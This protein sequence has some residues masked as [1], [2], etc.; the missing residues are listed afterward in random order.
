VGSCCGRR[1]S[2][3]DYCFSTRGDGFGRLDMTLSCRL[4]H[5][6]LLAFAPDCVVSRSRR[7]RI[8]LGTGPGGLAS[9]PA[10]R[11]APG[12]EPAAGAP[13]SGESY[14]LPSI[15][16]LFDPHLFKRALRAQTM[17]HRVST[18]RSCIGCPQEKTPAPTQDCGRRSLAESIPNC[19][20]VL[21]AARPKP[22]PGAWWGAV[23]RRRGGPSSSGMLHHSSGDER[24]MLTEELRA[25]YNDHI[26]RAHAKYRSTAGRFTC[27]RC[28]I[29]PTTSCA[30]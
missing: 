12:W 13:E 30:S 17:T 4:A 6:S 26:V 19:P 20:Y 16:M 7:G 24:R 8:R 10:W 15:L 2:N 21:D 9:P 1:D 28:C 27:T 14:S 5:L 3:R 22:K 29:L 11:V 23:R 25:A 18:P